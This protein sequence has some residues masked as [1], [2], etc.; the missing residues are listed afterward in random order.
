M[1]DG[2]LECRII[3]QGRGIPEQFRK[4]I[5]EPF[6]QVDAKDATTKKG[7]GLGL[8]ISRS[9]VEQ[10]GGT[11]GVDSEEGK[12]SAFWFKIPVETLAAQAEMKGKGVALSDATA[13][14]HCNSR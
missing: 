5:F 3:D 11:I 14:R 6:K 7:T 1:K 4:Q 2:F 10:H 12:G 8:T 13:F 9:I